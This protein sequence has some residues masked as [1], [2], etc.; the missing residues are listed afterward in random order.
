M[1]LS[2][3]CGEPN[4]SHGDDRHITMA[5]LEAA[6]Q[7]SNISPLQAA[8]NIIDGLRQTDGELG[9]DMRSVRG[10]HPGEAQAR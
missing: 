5:D 3:G 10:Q 4:A 9:T 8:E 7:A 2:C 6:A 1:C